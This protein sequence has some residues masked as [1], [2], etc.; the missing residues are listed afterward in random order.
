MLKVTT[1]LAHI[2]NTEDTTRA[3]DPTTKYNDWSKKPK[4]GENS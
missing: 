4:T 2:E 3:R 1:Y